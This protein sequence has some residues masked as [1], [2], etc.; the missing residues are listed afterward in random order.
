VRFAIVDGEKAEATP[1]AKGICPHCESEMIAK[2]CRAALSRCCFYFFLL[3][4]ILAVETCGVF[5]ELI[6]FGCGFFGPWGC[7]RNAGRWTFR[8]SIL[9]TATISD[10]SI[11]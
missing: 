2:C 7:L 3:A 1:K 11:C 9:S 6:L 10:V 5:L 4:I 8:A